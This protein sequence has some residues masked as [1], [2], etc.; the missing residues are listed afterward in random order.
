MSWSGAKT[1]E[2]QTMKGKRFTTEEK[3]RL[4]RDADQRGSI[5]ETCKEFTIPD[6]TFHRWKRQFAQMDLNV[7]AFF[8]PPW[9][10]VWALNQDPDQ[11]RQKIFDR[12]QDP[13]VA[14]LRPRPEHHRAVPGQEPLGRARPAF[15]GVGLGSGFCPPPSG[16]CHRRLAYDWRRWQ[17]SAG[18]TPSA[19]RPGWQKLPS[20][21]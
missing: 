11:E 10:T 21:L 13:P 16:R 12:R 14:G 7:T 15:I 3:I 9:V 20:I 18:G 5:T 8:G 2:A 17:R 1:K 19:P 4:L 6:T